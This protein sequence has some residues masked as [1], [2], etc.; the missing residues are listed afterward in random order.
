MTETNYPALF[1]IAMGVVAL[2][3]AAGPLYP[4][5]RWGMPSRK[6][7]WDEPR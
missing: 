1:C 7:W 2:W 3:A 4:Y 5:L 6:H